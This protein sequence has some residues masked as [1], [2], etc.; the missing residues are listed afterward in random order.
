M[1]FTT[2][3]SD[4]TAIKQINIFCQ[5]TEVAVGGGGHVLPEA[6][7]NED[8]AID[9]SGPVNA[10]GALAAGSSGTLSDAAARGWTVRATN[11]FPPGTGGVITGTNW[12]LQV[13]VLCATRNP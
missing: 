13:Y 8:V 10:N 3:L 12:A 2:S 11:L 9:L 7:P 6:G 5:A 4:L 1:S